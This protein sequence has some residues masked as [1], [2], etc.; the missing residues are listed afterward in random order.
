MTV[1]EVLLPFVLMGVAIVAV[2]VFVV[3]R[4]R[5]L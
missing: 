1:V 3:R 4:D 5:D 2:A